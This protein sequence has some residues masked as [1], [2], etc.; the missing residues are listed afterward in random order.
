MRSTKENAIYSSRQGYQCCFRG[1]RSRGTLCQILHI[2]FCWPHICAI[3]VAIF[4]LYA[5]VITT[6][7]FI[8]T[9]ST[10]QSCAVLILAVSFVYVSC[11][12]QCLKD[13]W[14]LFVK[15]FLRHVKTTSLASSSQDETCLC[16][17]TSFRCRCCIYNSKPTFY[18][19]Q[20][21]GSSHCSCMQL[22]VTL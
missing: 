5:C 21:N 9:R 20:P 10:A 14:Q 3:F 2:P 17:L 1:Y 11:L 13:S 16:Q 15:A 22:S 19:L 7:E 12:V 18:Y 8:A 4:N 6:H